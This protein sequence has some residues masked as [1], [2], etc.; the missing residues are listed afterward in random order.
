M[1]ADGLLFVILSCVCICVGCRAMSEHGSDTAKLKLVRGENAVISATVREGQSVAEILNTLG[2]PDYVDDDPWFSYKASPEGNYV[3]LFGEKTSKVDAKPD[4]ASVTVWGVRGPGTNVGEGVFLLP[5]RLRGKACGDFIALRV[6]LGPELKKVA[7]VALGMSSS[8]VL[9]LFRPAR[10]LA[11]KEGYIL[12]PSI[13]D[14]EFLLVFSAQDDNKNDDSRSDRLSEVMYRPGGQ[15]K[16][17]YLLPFKKRGHA[18][19]AIHKALLDNHGSRRN[20]NQPMQAT[21]NGAPDG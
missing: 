21:P 1:A 6:R 13:D 17:I 8:D 4:M 16:P 9:R 14:G 3:L 18:I 7:T 2:H 12:F 19:S 10:D 20:P 5:R 11:A 15:E